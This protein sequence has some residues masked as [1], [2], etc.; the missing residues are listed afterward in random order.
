M[1]NNCSQ[2]GDVEI[3]SCPFVNVVG[4]SNNSGSFSGNIVMRNYIDDGSGDPIR[5]E[6]TSA[7]GNFFGGNYMISHGN[8]SLADDARQ[9]QKNKDII[10]YPSI[11]PYI[12]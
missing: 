1:M 6:K 7:H 8:V 4:D 12:P 2:A 9:K 10:K 5:I 11:K 3:G